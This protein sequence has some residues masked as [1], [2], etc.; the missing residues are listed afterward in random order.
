[1]ASAGPSS[2][3]RRVRAARR[4]VGAGLTASATRRI[5][6]LTP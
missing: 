6:R 2:T 4:P 3:H 5:A 1:M